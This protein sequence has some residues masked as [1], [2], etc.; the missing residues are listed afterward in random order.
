MASAI[1]PAPIKPI[2]KFVLLL[3]LS[4]LKFSFDNTDSPFLMSVQKKTTFRF[5]TKS[6]QSAILP[7]L[8]DFSLEFFLRSG[9]FGAVFDLSFLTILDG[10]LTSEFTAE[11]LVSDIFF[12][13]ALLLI[14]L[15][16]SEGTFDLNSEPC[17][18]LI[19][20]ACFVLISEP[21][22]DLISEP[23]FDLTFELTLDLISE[24]AFDFL[25]SDPPPSLDL[26]V[27]SEDF[28][29]L[30][31]LELLISLLFGLNS[32]II[33][34]YLCFVLLQ[35]VCFAVGQIQNHN[36]ANNEGTQV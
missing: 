22:F 4:D 8:P 2:R 10:T 14:L 33:N 16:T 9:A 23:C 13:L 5:K 3:L 18:D 12:D 20:E 6:K 17:F 30:V 11:V 19:S 1:L 29:E 35:K 24:G 27:F 15:L 31:L 21:C 28:V 25:N 34:K 32:L 36:C 7:V 26:L